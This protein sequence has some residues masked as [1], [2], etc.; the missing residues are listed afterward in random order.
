MALDPGGG[1]TMGGGGSGYGEGPPDGSSQIRLMLD[2]DFK[3]VRIRVWTYEL[4]VRI[5]VG[6]GSSYGT[7]QMF[8]RLPNLNALVNA[9]DGL[10]EKYGGG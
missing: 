4:L 7:K 8:F 10:N 5:K 9:V 2:A 6:S 1:E 3:G